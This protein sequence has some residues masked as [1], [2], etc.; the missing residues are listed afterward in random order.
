MILMGQ[1]S[2]DSN[3]GFE[4][5]SP[6]ISPQWMM[7]LML[8][9]SARKFLVIHYMSIQIQIVIRFAFIVMIWGTMKMKFVEQYANHQCEQMATRL[10]LGTYSTIY[11]Q[12]Y[13][14]TH[15]H[16]YIYIHIDN[17]YI[18]IL[19]IQYIVY[20]DNQ[21]WTLVSMGTNYGFVQIFAKMQR[22]YSECFDAIIFFLKKNHPILT[23][24]L[25]F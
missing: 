12:T 13:Q 17:M 6:S 16:V 5:A 19:Y 14:P 18:P 21:N 9:I 15:L 11:L 4:F 8:L 25:W 7:Y 1:L 24:W 10:V 23:F 2:F 20:V 3:D 22:I